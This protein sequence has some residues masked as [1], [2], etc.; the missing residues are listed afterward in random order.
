MQENSLKGARVLIIQQR[1]WGPSIGHFLAQKLA[2][3]GCVLAAVTYKKSA[4]AFHVS[5]KDVHYEMLINNDEV[6]DD[7][8]RFVHGEPES[9]ETICRELGIRS[10]W[11][12]VAGSREITR[13]YG[14][15]YY[16]A[17][18]QQMP[19]EQITRY[20][21]GAYAYV[22]KIFDEF[23]PDVIIGPLIAEPS[24]LML[25]HIGK[26]RGVRT[27]YATDSKVRGVWVIA[28]S[29]LEDEGAFIERVDELNG[30]A[31]SPSEGRA[32][33]YI[34]SFRET[35]RAPDFIERRRKRRTYM[36]IVRGHIAPLRRIWEWYTRPRVN[37]VSALGPTLDCR[38]PR[39]V[40]R[41]Y[42]AQQRNTL[43]ASRMQYYPVENLGHYI[44]FPLQV[45]PEVTLDIFAS[46]FR[47]QRELVRLVAESLPDDYTLAVK[48]HPDMFGL[49]SPEF[50]KDIAGTP[51]AK[52]IDWRVPS[53]RLLKGC[54]LVVAPNS[55]ALTEAAFYCK[56][57]LQ[58]GDQGTT[59][60]MPNVTKH[61]DMKTLPD[62]IARLISKP[63][64]GDDYE[65]RLQNYVAAAY[66]TGFEAAYMDRGENVLKREGEDEKIWALYREGIVRALSA[67]Q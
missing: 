24:Q 66:D 29:P 32:R 31:S 30:G 35:F 22:Q 50:L 17:G 47:N 52:L 60:K 16:F 61:T 41:D 36:Q 23:K 3:E 46:N 12:L 9:L 59:Q 15:K 39:I 26:Q 58:F 25:Y 38:P 65:R 14:Q 63:L 54:A 2:S 56:P 6:F 33:S 28:E 5:Q 13:S 64:G 51:N 48:D 8:M 7:P 20:V 67:S 4:H 37:C 10:V 43:A 18:R 11:K 21:Q 27:L 55:T 40:I 42:V 44:F 45:E 34:A 19:D 62:V 1:N 53:E 57:A 49:R